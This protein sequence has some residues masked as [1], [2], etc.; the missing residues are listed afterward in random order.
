MSGFLKAKWNDH[1]DDHLRRPESLPIQCNPFVY[2]GTLTCSGYCPFC[3]GSP[4]LPATTQIYQFLDGERWRRHID[5]H[6]A[7]LAGCKATKYPHP[8]PKC[9]EDFTSILELKLHLQDVHCI[10]FTKEIKR[11]RS[12]SE[13]ETMPASKEEVQTDQG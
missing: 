6:I 5:D 13:E 2:S 12:D 8:R 3:L 11:R 9:V 7:E 10:E 4:A 1:C